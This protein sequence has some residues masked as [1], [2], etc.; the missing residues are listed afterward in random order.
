M[1][2]STVMLI[3]ELQPEKAELPMLVTL[4]GMVTAV[5]EPQPEKAQLSILVPLVITTVFSEAGM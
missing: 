1:P 3:S 4:S 2:A 5:S